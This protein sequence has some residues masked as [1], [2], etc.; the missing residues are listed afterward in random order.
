[1]RSLLTILV[2]LFGC[3]AAL[4]Q[5][6]T[7]AALADR[8]TIS[9]VDVPYTYYLTTA[10]VSEDQRQALHNALCFTLP[11]LSSKTDLGQQ[12]PVRVNETLYRMDTRG[13][14]WEQTWPKVLIEHYPFAK[15]QTDHGLAPLVVRADWCVAALLDP[16]ESGDSQYQLLYGKALGTDKEFLD[17]WGIQNDPEYV[18]G[19]IEGQS[20]VSVQRTR[21]I[22]NRPGAK[23]NYGWLTHD[24]RVVAG[25][26]DP[27]ENLPNKG[28]YDASELIVG[29]PKWYAGQS[30]VLQ[31]YFL[32]TGEGKRQDKAPADIVVDHTNV[33]GVEIRNSISCIAC[34]TQA[35]LAPSVDEWKQYITSGA[36]VYA[37][38]KSQQAIDRYLGSDVAKE[39]ARN[40]ADYA[41]GVVLCNGLSPAANASNFAAMVKAYDAPL[42]LE[43]AA[44]EL[45]CTPEE[46]RLALGDYSRLYGLNGRMAIL[47]S[48][49]TITRQQ[50]LANYELAKGIIETWH[51]Q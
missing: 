19:M 34:H 1:M 14:G 13:L 10:T 8:A 37:D 27:L 35:L 44:R 16:I 28:K 15:H 5:S 25:K 43:Q 46:L 50:W 41:T 45:Y 30:G 12:L 26:T 18:F 40:N 20:G 42:D 4:A 11:S 9:P 21:L 49:Q 2:N 33:R 38:K 36:R 6:P 51:A 3:A 32:S 39:I 24:S 23:R 22:E 29:I 48:G 31:A 17:F 7:A 47:A